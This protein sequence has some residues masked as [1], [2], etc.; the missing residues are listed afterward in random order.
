MDGLCYSLLS[1]AYERNTAL[2]LHPRLAQ[3]LQ[4]I[5]VALALALAIQTQQKH[6][7]ETMRQCCGDHR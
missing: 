5:V 7:D 3:I 2:D 6:Q 4:G 1:D